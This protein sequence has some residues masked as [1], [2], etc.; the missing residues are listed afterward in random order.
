MS[1]TAWICS[2]RCHCHPFYHRPLGSLFVRR[3]RPPRGLVFHSARGSEYLGAILRDRLRALGVRQSSSQR[4]PED[5][6]HMESF[7]HTL[8]AELV[9]GTEF[10]T[11]TALRAAI[12]RYVRY[13]NRERLHS[14]L[15]Y[16]SPLDYEANA[17]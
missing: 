8:K 15:D 10:A 6:A 4:G 13:Y 3:R 7:F 14:A 9:H 16:Q 17:A 12:A 11:T 2:I 1:Q 5:N